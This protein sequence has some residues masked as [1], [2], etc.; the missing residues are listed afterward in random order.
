MPVEQLLFGHD[1]NLMSS[2]EVAVIFTVKKMCHYIQCAD[3]IRYRNLNRFDMTLMVAANYSFFCALF[4][5]TL[6]SISSC[7]VL[8]SGDGQNW[9]AFAFVRGQG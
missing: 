3:V 5:S 9:A 2:L 4:L 6:P 7:S 8:F 1:D